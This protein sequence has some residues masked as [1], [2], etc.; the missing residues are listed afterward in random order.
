MKIV[1]Q[2]TRTIDYIVKRE[3]LGSVIFVSKRVLRC[4]ADFMSGTLDEVT[5]SGLVISYCF[6][7]VPFLYHRFRA[8]S[9]EFWV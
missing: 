7:N 6:R 1:C 4:L 3:I 2:S 9:Q 8:S 5:L